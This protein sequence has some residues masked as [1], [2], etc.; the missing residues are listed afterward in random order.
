MPLSCTVMTHRDTKPAGSDL[1]PRDRGV[2]VRVAGTRL[3]Y[4]W[5]PP[6]ACRL[7][8]PTVGGEI[9][10]FGLKKV[11]EPIRFLVDGERALLCHRAWNRQDCD[12]LATLHRD[13]TRL[14]LAQ[15]PAGMDL[16]NL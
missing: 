4:R 9:W 6:N 2:F 12:T 10:Q 1:V 8:R 11:F 5:Q 3:P 14:H 15:G 7:T 16:S 13:L